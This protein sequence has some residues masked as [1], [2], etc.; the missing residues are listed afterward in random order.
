MTHP[1][2]DGIP[3]HAALEYEV[4]APSAVEPKTKAATGG[5]AA[6]A[7][8]SAFVL[9]AL[10]ELIWNGADVPPEV[11]LPVA[12]FVGLAITAGVTFVSSYKARHVNRS[13]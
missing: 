3:Q 11:P 4:V 13:A 5:A 7:V 1:G 10:D 6:G 8:T 2:N 12:A 9:W